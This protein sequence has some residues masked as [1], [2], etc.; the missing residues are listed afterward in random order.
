MIAVV[1]TTTRFPDVARYLDQDK[2]DPEKSRAAHVWAQNC[3]GISDP[4]LAAELMQFYSEMNE[5]VEKPVYHMMVSFGT[6]EDPTF[7]QM[8]EAAKRLLDDLAL[9]EHQALL[10]AHTDRDHPHFHLMVNRVHPET[11]QCWKRDFDFAR[12]D[13]SLRQIE[14]DMGF[15]PVPGT[16]APTPDGKF[17][18]RSRTKP[19]G[20]GRMELRSAAD[21]REKH[22]RARLS[23]LSET[24]ESCR[25]DLTWA[26][27]WRDLEMR[28]A[29]KGLRL[30]RHARGLAVT[31]GR[32]GAGISL[33][34]A[35]AS[36]LKLETRFADPYDRY[37]AE[38]AARAPSRQPDLGLSL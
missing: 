16:L 21:A 18:D 23:F 32:H 28:L 5:K 11:Y 38:R 3:L 15:R 26:T 36:L 37:A 19:R 7:A 25:A 17:A 12:V 9:G 6:D 35:N 29:K 27:G 22:T 10:V 4:H 8:E 2:T 20:A 30:E 14:A 1:K 13:K 31:D 24:R 33:I 34:A